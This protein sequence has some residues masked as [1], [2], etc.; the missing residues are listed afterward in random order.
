MM[1]GRSK[2]RTSFADVEHRFH[3]AATFRRLGPHAEPQN[4]LAQPLDIGRVVNEPHRLPDDMLNRKLGT[5]KQLIDEIRDRYAKDSRPA[6]I[7]DDRDVQRCGGRFDPDDLPD[8]ASLSEDEFGGSE[9]GDGCF[10]SIDR[11]DVHRPDVRNSRTPPLRGRFNLQH[12]D[13]RCEAE[14]G[15]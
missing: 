2:S 10:F 15:D 9:V 5:S 6:V 1:T 7:D 12:Q 14:V 8:V 11:A 13:R 4:R 3:D